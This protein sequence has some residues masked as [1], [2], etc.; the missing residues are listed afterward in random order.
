MQQL[1]IIAYLVDFLQ[2]HAALNATADGGRFVAGEIDRGEPPQQTKY[3]LHITLF[4]GLPRLRVVAVG[5]VRVVTDASDFPRNAH[6]SQNEVDTARGDRAGRHAI[7]F[8][9]CWFLGERNPCLSLD[10]LQAEGAVGSSSGK[11][12]A[13]GIASVS[14][15]QGSQEGID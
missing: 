6:G 9:G 2:S 3:L 10:C 4:A 12:D 11:D 14:D 15:G 5:D 8:R 13:D 1:A 7:V